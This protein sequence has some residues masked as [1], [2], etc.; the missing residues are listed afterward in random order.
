MTQSFLSHDQLLDAIIG[1]EERMF[2]AVR[3]SAP[4]DCQQHLQTFRRMRRMAHY[5]LSDD[6]LRSY[7]QDLR[8]ASE[9]NTPDGCCMVPSLSEIKQAKDA[10]PKRNFFTEKYARIEDLIPPLND[11]PAIDKILA[12]E[13]QW[14]Q[15]LQGRYPKLLQKTGAFERYARAELETYSDRTLAYHFRDIQAAKDAGR[16]LVEE[17]YAKLCEMLKLESLAAAESLPVPSTLHPREGKA[18]VG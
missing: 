10:L 14:F 17:R 12:I 5:V 11:N 2:V 13:T 8:E 18:H 16:N 1:L 6:T 9:P 4:S 3:A 7:L 15:E